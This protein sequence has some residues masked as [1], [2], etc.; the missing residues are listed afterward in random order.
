MLEQERERRSR[1]NGVRLRDA[2]HRIVLS[3]S[4]IAIIEQERERR[5]RLNGVR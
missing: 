4:Q 5:S 3:L 1:L 2:V